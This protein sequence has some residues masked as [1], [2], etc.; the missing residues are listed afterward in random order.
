MTNTG[1][2][3]ILAD[4]VLAIHFCFVVFVV[5]GQLL[6][7]IGWMRRW[8]WTRKVLFRVLHVGAILYV[9]MESWVGAVCPL[10]SLENALRARI[11]D[12]TYQMTFIGTWLQ[13]LLFYDA[14]TWVFTLVY[15]L[16]GGF[17]LVMLV[18]YPP[19][20]TKDI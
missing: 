14:P 8:S 7:F 11:G 3:S 15:T 18:V 1:F 4:V 2:Y 10:T 12:E 6:I 19:E 9:V 17:V 5:G 16:F 20:R 13:R